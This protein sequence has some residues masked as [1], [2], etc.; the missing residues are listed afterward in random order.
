MKK[1]LTF[2]AAAMLGL[3]ATGCYDDSELTSR[4]DVLE[5][6]VSDLEALCKTMNT[7]ITELQTIV[8]QYKNAVTIMSV[9]PTDNGYEIIFNNGKKATITNG[10]KGER[11]S[12]GIQG[13]QGLEGP[14]GP[15]GDSPV[16]GVKTE[17]GILY[18]TVNGEILL[19]ENGDKVS[20]TSSLI[21]QFDYNAEEETWYISL[22]GKEWKALSG[23]M[24]HCYLFK[25]VKEEDDKV[26]FTLQDGSTIEIPKEKPFSF[27]LSESKAVAGTGS[28]IEIPYTLTGGDD[29]TIID[30]IATG[31]ITAVVNTEKKVIVI[32][33][34]AAV[35]TGKVV[36]FAT[37]A[38]K[39]IIRVINFVGC[40]FTVSSDVIKAKVAGETITFKVTT[41]LEK[42]GYKVVIPADCDW[43]SNIVTKAAREDEY[44]VDVAGNAGTTDR[45][46]QISLQTK[47]GVEIAK[48]TISQEAGA[49]MVDK[50]G[51]KVIILDTDNQS[52]AHAD[53]VFDG[54]WLGDKYGK[55]GAYPNGDDTQNQV[56][57]YKSFGGNASSGPD[58]FTIDAGKEIILAKFITYL[59]YSYTCNDPAVWEIYRYD[60]EGA[61]AQSGEWDN[62]TKIGSC[63]I[64]TVYAN[65]IKGKINAGDTFSRMKDG[66]A[67]DVAKD[68]AARYYRFKML[69]NGY[70]VYQTEFAQ[71][72][73]GRVHWFSISEISLY[74]YTY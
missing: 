6:K 20:V 14:Q 22:D 10:E 55:Y 38:D 53:V 48:I 5:T 64:S 33:A 3:M 40:T 21:P 26:I 69:K 52:Y 18:W 63:D 23:K 41:D 29:A 44:S 73:G 66:E 8:E 43:I 4:V 67:I 35:E 62:W 13:K 61:P 37:C 27:T 65:E 59:Y 7:N 51:C 11:G 15:Q 24:D 58:C 2:A 42:D 30:C 56:Y 57:S 72:W 49:K 60:G 32:T 17:D 1:I 68:K 47:A 28:T 71:W 19:D 54:N 31:N 46:A 45:S 74:E 34:P 9:T 39:S 25:D 70:A 50:T 12:Q 36:V 16:I